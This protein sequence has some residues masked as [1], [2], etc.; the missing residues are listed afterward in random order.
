MARVGETIVNAMT[1]EEIT[2]RRVEPDLLEWDDV[3]AQPGHRAA[4][5]VHPRMEERWTVVEGRA[6]F[7]I[8]EEEDVRVLEAGESI[9]AAP[10]VPHE[11][12]NPTDDR[13]VL[14]VTMTP[15]GRWAE[16][17]ELLFAWAAEGR[18]DEAGTPDLE[19]LVG[20]LRDYSEEIAPPPGVTRS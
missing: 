14:R 19:L 6:A 18:T 15:A 10:G 8:G 9:V 20:L 11:G 4:P 2:W 13:V 5:H 1:G 17:V 3:W 16:V 7:R 12:W